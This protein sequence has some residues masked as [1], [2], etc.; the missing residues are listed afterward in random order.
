MSDKEIYA[1]MLEYMTNL[2]TRLPHLAP[3]IEPFT[4]FTDMDLFI[5]LF[6][7]REELCPIF[8]ADDDDR[9]DLTTEFVNQMLSAHDI[10]PNSIPEA[11]REKI[12]LYL[13][14]WVRIV[15]DS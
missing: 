8:D 5:I 12:R 1:D 15:L 4:R 3:L 14:F 9:E 13:L 6:K 11:D 10:A 2:A 7:T